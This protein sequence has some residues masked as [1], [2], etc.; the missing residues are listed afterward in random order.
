MSGHAFEPSSSGSP[1][2]SSELLGF[3]AHARVL[4]V[5]CDDF[6][7]YEA[8]NTAVIDSMERGI[9]TSCSL[10][11]SCLAAPQALRMLKERPEIPFGVHLT[12]VCETT[13]LRWGTL[14][15]KDRVPSL[16]DDSGE[17][18]AP[19]PEGRS[20]LLA[21][22]RLDEVEHEFRAQ[23]D[24]VVDTGLMPTH[25]D[26]HCL[27]DGGRDD[28]LDLTVAL[29][30]E[31]G[32][33]VRVWL[34]PGRRKARRRGLPVVDNPFLDSFSVGVEGKFARYAELLRDLPAGLSEWAVHPGLGDEESRA[35]DDGWRVRRTDHEFLTSPKARELLQAEG[36]VV[37]DYR[38]LQRVWSQDGA[39][40]RGGDG[41]SRRAG[42]SCGGPVGPETDPT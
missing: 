7:M 1:A 33:A 42:P 39:S 13:G 19:T 24:A 38:A 6:G 12:L 37:I 32:L 18:F 30:D 14:A 5:N 29:A 15:E 41:L 31:Y 28:I 27:A 11:V 22:A 35:R 36:I 20:K 3:P 34:E 26:F 25:L 8:I 9:A 10:M 40:A 16:L 21:R 17:L 23:I 2:L 4:I